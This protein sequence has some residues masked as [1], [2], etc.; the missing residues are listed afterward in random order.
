VVLGNEAHEAV[1]YRLPVVELI[2][3]ENEHNAIGHLGPDLLG[4]DWDLEVAVANLSARPNRSVGEALLDQ[5]NLAGLGTIY[6]AESC[7]VAGVSPFSPLGA[8]S[9]LRGLVVAAQRQLAAG[10]RDPR[11]GT[12]GDPR[13]RYWVY[14]RAGLP[15]RRCGTLI[16]S[17]QLGPVGVE[18]IVYWCARCQ[19]VA[20]T[21]PEDQR[22]V[23]AR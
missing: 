11:G 13:G 12:R 14:G 1:G 5:R 3:T 15:C 16:S 8:V 10:A 4:P 20:P 19:P 9:G 7:F 17:A 18:R 22:R 2:R 21:T 23:R 6:R